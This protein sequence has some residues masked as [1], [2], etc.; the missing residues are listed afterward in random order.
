MNRHTGFLNFRH[1]F[2]NTVSTVLMKPLA[3]CFNIE[4]QGTVR[5]E[6]VLEIFASLN[7]RML[8]LKTKTPF[9]ILMRAIKKIS[10][11]KSAYN[12]DVHEYA[13]VEVEKCQN[14]GCTFVDEVEHE[15]HM[16]A[17]HTA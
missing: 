12:F 13:G 14:C 7:M 2:N 5:Q 17:D 3:A 10:W 1:Y 15:W 11:N 9:R 6:P 4:R 8:Y 16:P